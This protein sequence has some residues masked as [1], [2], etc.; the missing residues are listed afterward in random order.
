[1]TRLTLLLA[2]GALP[3]AAHAQD[4]TLATGRLEIAATAA[5]ACVIRAPTAG[6]GVNAVFEPVGNSSGHVR[7]AELVDPNSA[8]PRPASMDLVVPVICN[9]PHRVTLRSGSGGL[10]VGGAP[11]NTGGFASI[12]P[13]SMS[14]LWGS[15]RSTTATDAGAPL[16]LDAAQAR[17]GELSLKIAVASSEKPLVAGTYTDQIILEFQAAN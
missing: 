13:Y 8:L 4:S 1:M 5:S 16:V 12:L 17:A 3:S 2:L 6:T 11:A 9:G 14:L 7:I 15:D 10:R